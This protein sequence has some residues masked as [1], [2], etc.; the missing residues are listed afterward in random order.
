MTDRR[1]GIHPTALIGSPPEHREW[2]RDPSRADFFPEIDPTALI[3]GFVTVDSGCAAPTKVGARTLL[4]AHVHIG[5]DAI[6]GDDC[7]LAPGVV[8]GGSAE[9]GSGVKIGLNAC[10]LPFI[11]VG[12]GARVGAGAVVTRDVPPYTVVVGNPAHPIHK[13]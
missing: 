3:N 13:P 1:S 9:I 6:V 2:I 8:I 7:E 12:A 11:T 4:M 5:H 10:V